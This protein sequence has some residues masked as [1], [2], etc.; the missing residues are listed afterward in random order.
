VKRI[1]IDDIAPNRAHQH[2]AN[3]NATHTH[4]VTPRAE[5]LEAFGVL[6]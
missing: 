4:V 5:S 3:S 6:P 1:R 2:E